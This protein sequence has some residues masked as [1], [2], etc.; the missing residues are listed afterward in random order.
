MADEGWTGLDRWITSGENSHIN[1]QEVKLTD[2]GKCSA[3]GEAVVG[4]GRAEWDL[5]IDFESFGGIS[6][7]IYRQDLKHRDNINMLPTDQ[8]FTYT[9]DGYGYANKTG[10]F[11]ANK[12]RKKYGIRYRHGDKITVRLDL[13]S[14][15]LTFLINDESQGIAME[16]LPKGAYRLACC[17]QFKEQKVSILRFWNSL[18]KNN[19][20]PNTESTQTRTADAD[21][22]GKEHTKDPNDDDYDNDDGTNGS[23][24]KEKL[25]KQKELYADYKEPEIDPDA[26][27][28]GNYDD[29][30]GNNKQNDD[31]NNDEEEEESSSAYQPEESDDEDN[32]PKPQSEEDKMDIDDDTAQKLYIKKNHI[33]IHFVIF[34]LKGDMI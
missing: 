32:A 11:T 21:K 1:E 30:T 33:K 5:Q 17:M 29:G 31:N 34:F 4:S 16:N 19:T 15:D 26:D 14:R 2:K 3:Y 23:S 13:Q 8:T 6:I 18:G 12:E 24:K 27:W 7:G 28:F 25:K 20:V 10:A 22:I 9:P